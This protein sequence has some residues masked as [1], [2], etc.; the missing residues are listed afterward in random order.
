MGFILTVSILVRFLGLGLTLFFFLRDRRWPILFLSALI[1]LMATRQLLTLGDRSVPWLGGAWTSEIPGLAV[2]FLILGIVLVYARILKEDVHRY[3]FWNNIPR[4]TGFV[5]LDLHP[6]QTI[7][8][9]TH[10]VTDLLGFQPDELMGRSFRELA[11]PGTEPRELPQPREVAKQEAGAHITAT[12]LS[13]DGRKVPVHIFLRFFGNP[14]R[15]RRHYSLV[16]ADRREEVQS[17]ELQETIADLARDAE[18]IIANEGWGMVH[19]A[20]RGARALEVARVNIWW[21]SPDHSHLRCAENFDRILQKHTAGEILEVEHYPDYLAALTESRTLAI[22]DPD[23]DPRTR[24]LAAGYLRPHGITALLDAPILIEGQVAGVVCFEHMGG[25]RTWNEAEVAFAGSVADLVALARTAGIHRARAEHLAHQAYL[26]P[27]TGLMNW[28]YLQDR[29]Q[30]EVD[31]EQSADRPALALL[32]IDL[33]QF[34]YVNDTMGHAAGDRLLAEVARDIREVSPTDALVGRIGGD[35][36]VVVV[37]DR[38]AEGAEKLA[39]KVRNRVASSAFESLVPGVTLSVSIGLAWMDQ[40]TDSAGELLAGGDQACTQAKEAGRNQV[41]VYR[42]SEAQGTLVNKRLEVF[43][44]LRRA[45]D[46]GSFRLVFHPIRAVRPNGEPD[47]HEVLLRMVEGD[48]LLTPG[49]FLRTAEHFRLM[50]EIDRWVVRQAIDQLAKWR[51]ERPD[52]SFSVNIS[53]RAFGDERLFQ[54][55]RTHIQ[56]TGV[57]PAALVFEI[58]ET[59]AIANLSQAKAMIWNLRELGCRFALD[60]FGSGFASFAYLRELP[61]DLVKIDGKFVRELATSSLDQAI[62]R[63]LVDISHALGK[64]VVAEFVEDQPSLGL[65]EKLG[66]HYAQG[67]FL[68]RPAEHPV[69]PELPAGRHSSAR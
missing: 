29:I 42:P 20:E 10:T 2:S 6:D 34:R 19:I 32:Y 16:L 68:A 45:L 24:N 37:F 49:E 5:F 22:N 7:R 50:G 33:D 67:F 23:N 27:V 56:E 57:E 47:L 30:E 12:L 1:G 60:D 58:T 25:P 39:E 4:E 44:R 13:A 64:E 26:D 48:T 36:L 43:H 28:Q 11:A 9:A 38:E 62:V 17:A 31:R 51:R 3:F 53:A 8:R 66:V 69:P 61:V 63:A 59:E 41:V 21:L 40:N 18:D 35:E 65:L 52:L 46:E 55:I 54:E 14:F 15:G